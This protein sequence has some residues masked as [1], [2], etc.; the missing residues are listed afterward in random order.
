VKLNLRQKRFGTFPVFVI[1]AS[2]A[3]DYMSR[4]GKRLAKHDA[5]RSRTNDAKG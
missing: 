2:N 5:N 3:S 1:T 4:R